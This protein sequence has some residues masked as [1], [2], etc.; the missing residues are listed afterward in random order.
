L[1]VVYTKGYSVEIMEKEF[2]FRPDS[3]FAQNPHPPSK[4]AKLLGDCLMV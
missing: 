4:L 1:K 3:I 2:S